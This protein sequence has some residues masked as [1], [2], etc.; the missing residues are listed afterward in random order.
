[1]NN[2][3]V[4]I[5]VTLGPSS[6]KYEIIRR[7]VSEGVSGFRINYS[8]GEPSIWDEW[9][10]MI[11]EVVSELERRVSI[12]G[13]LPGPQVRIGEIPEQEVKM[14]QQVRLVYAEKTEE[15]GIIPIPV[16]KFFETLELGDTVLIDDGR[17]ILRIIDVDENE[18]TGLVLNDAVLSPRKTIIIFGKEIDLPTLTDKDM[19]YLEFSINKKLSYIAL[20]FVRS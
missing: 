6:A 1:M 14:K 10:K 12:I 4:K 15:E 9:I 7:L 2:L 16:K 18:A 8:H 5:L 3:R 17:I 11:N 20:S 19:E 13:D